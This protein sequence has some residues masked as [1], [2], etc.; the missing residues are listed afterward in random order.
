MKKAPICQPAG[1]P[2]RQTRPYGARL[3]K[4]RAHAQQLDYPKCDVSSFGFVVLISLTLLLA[5]LTG[6]ASANSFSDKD[7]IDGFYKTVFGAEIKSLSWG[8]QT[9]R[10]KKY[11]KPVKVWIDNRAKLNRLKTVRSFVR[12]LPSK[13][14]GLQLHLARTPKEANFR[15]YIVDS[16]NYQ[17]TVQ[18]EV[19]HDPNMAV[20]GQ[21]I[22][23]VLSRRSGILRSDAVIVSDQGLSLF[24][25]CMVEE[26]LQGLGPVNDD[27]SLSYSVFNDLTTY[28]AFTKYDRLILNML[29]SPSVKPG[30]TQKQI[31]PLTPK[32]L[33]YAKKVV[34][35]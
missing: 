11:V 4:A 34:G 5:I 21:C 13:I 3:L 12:G 6:P 8:T 20:P 17:R 25:R 29:Y 19:F 14:P 33:H 16:A 15:I 22:V 10:V 32:L 2:L 31:H 28:D 23:R 1:I 18:D 7:V 9:N 26:I 30:M 24:R 27:A 35:H